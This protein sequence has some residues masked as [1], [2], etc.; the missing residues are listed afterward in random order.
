MFLSM[1]NEVVWLAAGLSVLGSVIMF[2]LSPLYEFFKF[3]KNSV[4]VETELYGIM[5]D[6]LDKSEKTGRSVSI[7]L[8]HSKNLEDEDED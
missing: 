5:C 2:F 8:S 6:A 1:F 3:T 7:I 4:D